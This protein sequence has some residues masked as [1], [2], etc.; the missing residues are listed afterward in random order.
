MAVKIIKSG[1]QPL[2]VGNALGV[3]N[4]VPYLTLVKTDE[5]KVKA[6]AEVLQGTDIEKDDAFESFFFDPKKAD[7][8]DAQILR[9]PFN[10]KALVHLTLN[11]NT[12]GQLVTAM[13]VNIDGT[14]WT[15]TKDEL[16]ESGEPDDEKDTERERLMDWFKEP[17]PR[18]SFTTIRRNMRRDLESIGNG[19]LEVLRAIDGK[20][21]FLKHI[22]ASQIRLVK[23]D[24]AVPVEQ[25]VKRDGED[26]DILMMVRERRFAQKQGTKLVY[27]KEYGAS[28]SLDRNTGEWSA[29][30]L[31]AKDRATE[32]IWFKVNEDS[33]TPY[34]VPRWVNQI[35]SVLGSR[36]AEELNLDFFNAGGLPPAMI[37][38]QGGEMTSEMRK[39]L[40]AYLSGK[41]SSYHRAAV[42]EV[43]ST[44][45]S[46]DSPGN[47]RVTVE[48]FGSERM[49]DSMFEKYDA[50]C[51]GRVRGSFRLPP[52][53]MGRAEDYSFASAFASYTV[54][55]A[56]VF[57]P[58]RMEF[59][60]VINNTVMRELD[61]ES[62]YRYRSLPLTVNDVQ[63][64]LKALEIT[65]DVLTP[66]GF[67]GAINEATGME[68]KASEDAVM[69]PTPAA[70]AAAEP[71]EP[72]PGRASNNAQPN[73]IPSR[74][75]IQNSV[76]KYDT[77][78][79]MELVSRWALAQTT[80]EVPPEEVVQI[81]ETIKS[82]DVNTRTRFDGYATMRMMSGL[83][84]DLQGATELVGAASEIA[85][86]CQH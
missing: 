54:S 52:L 65:K 30:E 58:E 43:H 23:L 66:E 34:G 1:E 75:G 61:P 77:F 9:P 82:M 22:P 40:Q 70:P 18:V 25:T 49:N 83:D 32:L 68:L 24:E 38:I 15:V 86:G 64:Q 28:R 46:I 60:E 16:T 80:D 56:Q 21:T 85:D 13:E 11:N 41:G 84:Y 19:Y 48:R 71:A 79:L 35:P 2:T 76:E 31:P 3:S 33:M 73:R 78:D 12:L 62:V 47:V 72:G 45:G 63:T 26:M 27:F 20:L 29:D 81:Q 69:Q 4:P 6:D 57:L 59:D 53:F 5:K 8:K 55:E 17:F 36:K 50:R 14:G 51:E 67:I 37:F 7:N 44:G 39:Q 74:T 42:L 10:P